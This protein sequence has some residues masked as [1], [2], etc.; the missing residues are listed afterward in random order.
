MS[1]D[2]DRD[3]NESVP[4]KRM[5]YGAGGTEADVQRARA[6]KNFV[7]SPLPSRDG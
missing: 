5:L 1:A 7:P 4:Q 6:E 3:A 2:S